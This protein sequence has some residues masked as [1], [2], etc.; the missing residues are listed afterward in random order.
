MQECGADVIHIDVMDGHFV[1]N[2]TFGADVISSIRRHTQLFFDVHL[3]ISDPMR[4]VDDFI[5]AG[6]DIITFHYESVE[7]PLEVVLIVITSLVGIFSVSAAL[8]GYVLR[9]M[10]WWQRI[11]IAVGGLLLIY[12]GLVTDSIGLGLVAVVVILQVM[13]KKKT[14]V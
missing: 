3:T 1:P 8:E 7:N 9:N 2:I 5:R 13:A 6:A 4:Y 14:V 12:P 10:T 11:I